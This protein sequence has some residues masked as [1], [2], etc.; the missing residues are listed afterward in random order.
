MIEHECLICWKNA[1]THTHA[2]SPTVEHR[3]TALRTSHV[4]MMLSWSILSQ[5]WQTKLNGCKSVIW[6]RSAVDQHPF[7]FQH[8]NCPLNLW[9]IQS[10]ISK[11]G[12]CTRLHYIS[13]L[14]VVFVSLLFAPVHFA[15]VGV[16][17]ISYFILIV[18]PIWILLICTHYIDYILIIQYRCNNVYIL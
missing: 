1:H 18:I 14:V 12:V 11:L 13:V 7:K 10:H 4:Q 6:T 8:T 17:T 2:H 16:S 9:T 15:F 3:T 5:C